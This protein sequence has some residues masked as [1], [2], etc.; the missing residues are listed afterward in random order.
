MTQRNEVVSENSPLNPYPETIPIGVQLDPPHVTSCGVNT[1]LRRTI[2]CPWP[3][4]EAEMFGMVYE[5]AKVNFRLTLFTND[6]ASTE[7]LKSGEIY[8]SVTC[9]DRTDQHLQVT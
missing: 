9:D 5:T 1:S 2:D 4:L 7:A 8:T 3:G 6:S